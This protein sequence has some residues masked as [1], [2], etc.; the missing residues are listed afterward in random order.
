MGLTFEDLDR[1]GELMDLQPKTLS[2][3]ASELKIERT[4]LYRLIDRVNRL[5]GE[6]TPEWQPKS[7]SFPPVEVRRLVRAFRR[8]ISAHMDLSSFPRVSAGSCASLLLLEYLGDCCWPTSRIV[9]VRSEDALKALRK[10]EIDVAIVHESSI[11]GVLDQDRVALRGG[12]DLVRLLRWHAVVVRSPEGDPAQTRQI[13]RSAHW[14]A[15]GVGGR[16]NRL[17]PSGAQGRTRGTSGYR[18]TSFLQALEMVR[19]RLIQMTIL[20]DIYLAQRDL[21]LEITLPRRQHSEC[22]VAAYRRS[23]YSRVEWLLDPNRWNRLF[24]KRRVTD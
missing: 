21:D 3:G 14:E 17:S 11:C 12:V 2:E 13:P 6:P 5:I 10:E 18:A 15:A 7:G 23:E 4:Y 8:L 20:P 16:L 9:L 1:L 24:G 19:R 22:L